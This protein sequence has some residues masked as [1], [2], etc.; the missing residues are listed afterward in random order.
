MFTMHAAVCRRPDGIASGCITFDAFQRLVKVAIERR[1]FNVC[2]WK[3]NAG[4]FLKCVVH[5]F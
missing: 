5:K 2:E 4:D 3:G 1:E